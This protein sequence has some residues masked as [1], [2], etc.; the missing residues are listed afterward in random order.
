MTM[1]P[2]PLPP[3]WKIGN[4]V[5]PGQ[6]LQHHRR[7]AGDAA[8]QRI[9][10]IGRD[11]RLAAHHAMRDRKT[12]SARVPSSRSARAISAAACSCCCVH[13]PWRATKSL[14]RF[15]LPAPARAS[16]AAAPL[17]RLPVIVQS[18]DRSDAVDRR[19]AAH[20]VGAAR[21]R[22][23][24]SLRHVV[25]RAE[26][27]ATGGGDDAIGVA[28]MFLRAILHRAHALD[29]PLVMHVDVHAHAGIG[30]AALFLRIVAPVVRLARVRHVIRQRVVLQSL[31]PH[32]C[33][34]DRCA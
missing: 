25:D 16:R 17:P 31:R 32:G 12:R 3:R 13:R 19:G 8:A 9:D 27:H 33:L 10:G 21:Q 23:I 18:V 1:S 4:A 11:Q 15:P 14:T 30:R 29:R 28:E 20:R 34:V 2:A 26:D 5:R 7:G 6:V 22:R 24:A